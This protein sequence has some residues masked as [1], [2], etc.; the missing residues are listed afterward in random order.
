MPFAGVGPFFPDASF[1]GVGANNKKI[2]DALPG[3]NQ[4]TSCDFGTNTAVRELLFKPNVANVTT[5]P[6]EASTGNDFGFNFTV[7]NFDA[8]ANLPA[9]RRVAAGSWVI[10]MEIKASIGQVTADTRIHVKVFTRT[11]AGVLTERAA[12][13]TA[14]FAALITNVAATV[15]LTV[16]ELIVAAGDTIHLEYHVESKGV[17]V[18]G[19]QIVFSTG[20][21]S[22]LIPACQITLPGDG[23][24]YSYPR[25]MPAA[26]LSLSAAVAKTFA[27]PAKV[28]TLTLAA[29]YARR[30]TAN[31][32]FA[33]ALS[34]T[35]SVVKKVSPLPKVAALT[36]TATVLKTVVLPAK[37]AALSLVATV[38]K[39]FQGPPKVATLT[40]TGAFSRRLTANRAFTTALTLN[41]VAAKRLLAARSFTT[42][43]TLTA[44]GRIDMGMVV[45]NR[46]V[47][48]GSTVIRKIFY[49]VDD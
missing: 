30:L 4:V 45:L 49:T 34:L 28:A 7:A 24:R 48:G 11:S 20:R 13:F 9:S 5:T 46:I 39:T 43:L 16:P 21:P 14:A 1:A 47:G 6:S 41:A 3:T 27:G 17:A 44:A 29:A 37:V 26:T 40:L 12:G 19:N 31:R 42:A 33:T 36:L 8:T 32:S 23:L 15:T 38:L 22:I 2:T 10:D 18:T 35:A 25:T